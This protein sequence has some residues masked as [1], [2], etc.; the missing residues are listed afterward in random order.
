MPRRP[1]TGG[2]ART[3]TRRAINRATLARQMLLARE[4]ITPVQAIER[5]VAMQAQLPRPPFVGLWSR[6]EAV[7]RSELAACLLDRTIVRATFI[8]ATLHLVTTADYL[9]LRPAIAPVLEASMRAILRG[10]KAD[11]FDV[12]ALLARARSLL[13]GTPRTFDELRDAFLAAEPEADERAMGYA[14]R[15]LLP[16]VQVPRED[17][18]WGYPAKARFALAEE[19]LGRPV[20]AGSG[21]EDERLVERY[22]A[23]Y[24]PASVADVQAWSGLGGLGPTLA[25]MAPRLRV[26]RDERGRE[27]FDLPDAPRPGADTAAPIRLVP[28]YDNVITAR[29]D[30][31]FVA[32]A[33]RPRVFLPGLRIAATVLVDGFVAGTWTLEAKRSA[34][35]LTISP[36]RNFSRAV[37]SAVVEEAESLARFAAPDAR[38]HEVRV[39]S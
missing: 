27:V 30:E 19:W 10:R 20:S 18:T 17:E 4:R 12:G 38:A 7:D 36:F 23:A 31:R 2:E 35:A 25:K 8:R 24:G 1:S 15:M 13:A 21:Q 39:A 26:F 6:L 3:L 11:G 34:A 5:L 37:R 22:L 33:D 32:R 29:A 14:V 9:A 16:L 28:E